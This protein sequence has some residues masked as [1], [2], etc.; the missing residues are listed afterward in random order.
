MSRSRKLLV[1]S[2]L[3]LIIWGMGYGLYYAIFDEHQTLE[4]IGASLAMGFA[5]AAK[6]ELTEAHASLDKYAAAKFEYARE[7]DVHSHWTALA[8]LLLLFGVFFDRIGYDETI[9]FYL[10]LVLVAGSVIFPLGVILQTV[11]QG[12]VPQVIAI[13][14]AGLLIAAMG[15]VA[16]GVL[17]QKE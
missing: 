10:A 3:A 17:Q 7:V 5:H 14:G 15:A 1:I 6:G 11:Q 8:M 16:M 4:T 13:A 12:M 9:R 2:G